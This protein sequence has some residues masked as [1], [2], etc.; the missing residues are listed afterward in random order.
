MAD[1]KFIIYLKTFA[2]CLSFF[3]IGLVISI[4]GPTILELQ[5]AVDVMYEDIIKI[6]P[7]RASGYA[8]G[9]MIGCNVLIL[10]MWGKDTQP[11]MQSMHFAFGLGGLVAPLLASPFLSAGEVPIEGL[12]L[13]VTSATENSCSP[14]E[15]QVYIPYAIVG[16]ACILSAILFLYLFICHR[17]TE[18]HHSRKE[19]AEENMAAG[20]KDEPIWTRRIVV[21]LTALFLFTL[22]GFE[23]GMGSFITSF[24]V[25]SDHHLTKQ[26][27]AYMTSLYWFTYTFFKLIFI[28][29]I[30]KIGM[31][32]NITLELG[33]LVVANIFLV[34]F[35]NSVLW[36]LWVGVAL[37]GIA[38]TTL[39]AAVFV[40]L[41]S[42]FPV[43]SG[44]ASFLTVSAC[45]GEWVYPVIMGY[46]MEADPQLF[47][48]V[49]FACTVI[50]CALFALLSFICISKL[51]PRPEIPT[52]NEVARVTDK[53]N[54]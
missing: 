9:S 43:T 30:A 26:V 41:E 31:Y 29:L 25:M 54:N 37:V 17:H 15:L 1:T 53:V 44:I 34:P 35:G 3:T 18:E 8:F 13:N 6:M 27:G 20:V 40:L 50:C 33:I 14:A 28:P 32:G 4:I 49:I 45:V 38:I 7:A 24:A 16:T 12:A 48:W 36:C 52:A 19:K 21:L 51:A 5:C 23:V 11:Y 22:L 42:Y 2:L 10:Y 39:W 47:L 46:A